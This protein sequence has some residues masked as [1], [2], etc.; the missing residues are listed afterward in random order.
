MAQ[1][2]QIK[3]MHDYLKIYAEKSLGRH[4]SRPADRRAYLGGQFVALVYRR[5]RLK[6]HQ[7]LRQWWRRWR[8]KG[9]C[10]PALQVP[11][12]A[13]TRAQLFLRWRISPQA[14]P[15]SSSHA[16]FLKSILEPSSCLFTLL[17]NPRDPSVTT[18]LRSANKFPRLPS[19]TIKYQTFISHAL[20]QYQST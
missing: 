12:L 19:R 10:V 14:R 7:N 2:I 9:P 13:I 17:P 5:W 16:S 20:S 1:P 6:S 11:A 18:R 4:S 15:F 3:C 8:G